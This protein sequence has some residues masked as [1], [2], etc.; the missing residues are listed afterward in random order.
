[1]SKEYKLADE[2]FEEL[3]DAGTEFQNAETA[4]SSAGELYRDK[5]DAY[6]DAVTKHVPESA[7]KHFI[8]V[9]DRRVVIV[10]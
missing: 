3:N 7:G 10:K 4:L 9:R 1:M 2:Q 6:M 5:R 8:L